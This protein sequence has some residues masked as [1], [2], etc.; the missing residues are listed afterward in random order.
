MKSDWLANVTTRLLLKRRAKDRWMRKVSTCAQPSVASTLHAA[1]ARVVLGH[2]EE[3]L[4][5]V[6]HARAQ[7]RRKAL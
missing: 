4:E 1:H 2:R 6:V 5:D 3:V 7:R